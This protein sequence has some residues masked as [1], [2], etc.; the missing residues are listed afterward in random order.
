MELRW[1]REWMEAGRPG[2]DAGQALLCEWH[3]LE[4]VEPGQR[5]CVDSGGSKSPVTR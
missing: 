3:K 4:G 1:C 5:S 2:Q